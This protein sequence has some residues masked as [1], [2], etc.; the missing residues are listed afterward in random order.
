MRFLP[1]DMLW[2]H[3][4]QVSNIDMLRWHFMQ[5]KVCVFRAYGKAR[6]RNPEPEPETEPEPEQEPEPKK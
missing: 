4:V 3:F 5:Y 2:S 1:F 6:I